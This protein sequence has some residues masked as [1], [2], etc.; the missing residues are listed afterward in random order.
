LMDKDGQ[1]SVLEGLKQQ[2]E[3]AAIGGAKW[4]PAD[5]QQMEKRIDGY[6]KEIE[7]CLALLNS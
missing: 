3:S 5:K 2:L 6:L 4:S 1:D 7:K